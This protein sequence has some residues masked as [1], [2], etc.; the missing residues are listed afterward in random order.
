MIENLLGCAQSNEF[1]T[2]LAN[3]QD[4]PLYLLTGAQSQVFLS[5]WNGQQ[6][7]QPQAQ[8]TLSGFEDPEIYTEINLGC[9][10]AALS[11]ERIYIVGCDQ[12]E[13]GDVWVTSR[14]LE[15]NTFLL[16]SPVWSQPSSI[17][18]DSLEME[19]V[20]VVATDDGLIH[21]FFSQH[22][23]PAIY[24]S[25]WD[26]ELWSHITP[27]LELPEG[28]TGWPAIASGPGNELFLIAPNNRGV[29]YFNRATSG[30]ASTTS[31]WSP[32]TRLEI[33]D[34]GKVGSVDVA[35]TAA[36]TIYVAY[37][38]PVNNERGIYLVQS[39]D[40]GATWSEPLQVFNGV[41][42]GF[43]LVGAPS[44]LVSE[45]GFLHM[46][47]K[48]QSIQGDGVPQPLS[49]Y[50]TR[51]ENGG[52]TF[53][54]AVLIV[55]EPVVWQEIVTDGNGNLHLLWQPQDTMT[56]VW[57]QVSM[58][59]GR[60]WQFPQGLPNEGITEA[61][62]VDSIGRLHVVDAGLGSLGHWLWDGNR[63]QPE[64]PLHWSLASQQEGPVELLAG[65]VNEQG[66]M[67]VVMAVPTDAVNATESTLLYSVRSLELPSGQTPIEEV[68]TQTLL[69]PTLTPII[70]TAESPITPASTIVSESA[71][72]QDQPI[73][74]ETNNPTSPFTIALVPVAFFY[75]RCWAL[76]F[77][78]P[79]GSRIDR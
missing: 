73:R 41:N 71:N 26:G 12:G 47:W 17:T 42:A 24:Y 27:V 52:L 33:G 58:D 20:E 3:N 62:I 13:G 61:M 19:A 72:S 55:D 35:W 65:A 53:G 28:E 18:D 75:S 11:R 37:S 67:V 44:L 21:V 6:W 14:D 22:Q 7:S 38:V 69:T 59:G 32:P 64:V 49:L 30:N 9:H 2:G 54:E 31:S 66:K 4:G 68:P 77:D 79:F 10:R 43:D 57:D 16:S 8:P 56:T 34:D 39:K 78:E 63:W 15:S 74:N 45:N 25:F 1:V 29:L 48:Q 50:Y 51:S 5:A 23:D 36:G 46:I 40:H 76:C 70:P 60:S